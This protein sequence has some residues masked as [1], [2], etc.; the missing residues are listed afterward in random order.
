LTALQALA[1]LNNKLVLA[2]ANRFA[3]RLETDQPERREQLTE[4]CQLALGRAPTPEELTDFIAFAG[5]HGL[6]NTC[7]LILNLNEFIFVD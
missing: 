1:L 4:A 3:Q 2:M 6:P 5:Q 7:R